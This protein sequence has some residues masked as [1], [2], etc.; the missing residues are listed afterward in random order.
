MSG[1]DSNQRNL[2]PV[3]V[4]E[5]IPVQGKHRLDEGTAKLE[6][7]PMPEHL[8]MY[9]EL[10]RG[11]MG[12][13]HPAT[14]RNLLRP[15]ALKRLDKRFTHT[16]F[17]RD[18]FIAEAQITGQL[19]H[20]NIVPVHELSID[21]G[22]VPYFTMKLVHGTGLDHWLTQR[23]PGTTDRLQ[24]GLEIFIKVCDAIAYAHHRGVIHRDIKPENI[25]V[26]DFGQVYVMDWG[27]ARLT[28]LAPASGQGAQMNTPG[29]VGTGDYM[30]P[31]QARGNPQDM[32]ERT[33][34]FGLGAVLYEIVS[35]KRPYGDH[36]DRK[37]IVERARDGRVVSIDEATAEIG[38]SK[39]LRQIVAKAI[40]VNPDERYQS[41]QAMKEEVRAFL[42]GG[43]HLPRQLFEAG[44]LI[45]EEGQP[46]DKAYM[47]IGG[48]C[49]AFRVVDGKREDLGT[50]GPGDVF[51]EM[52]LIL[53]E[54]RAASVEA[55]DRVAV[56][57]LDKPTMD[58]GLGMAGWTGALVSALAQRFRN[59]EQKVRDQGLRR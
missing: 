25:M 48:R 5:D 47:I 11:G 4:I 56:L 51:G 42:M 10:G 15:V 33:D 46:G 13:V 27:L 30:A 57:V 38:V 9:P 7:V 12:H 29:A 37:V 8:C 36:F 41:V 50:M 23:A 44:D 34:V 28:R 35:G 54:P 39:R 16:Q 3:R 32:D 43:L 24:E 1:S 52:A 6:L 21:P 45:I 53:D 18:G 19:E 40:S 17:Y 2:K 26:A 55:V 20:P 31:E 22:G 58:E 14:D 49:R 59:L